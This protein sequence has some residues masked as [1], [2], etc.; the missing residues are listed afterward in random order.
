MERDLDPLVAGG[1]HGYGECSRLGR[2]AGHGHSHDAVPEGHPGESGSGG[3]HSPGEVDVEQGPAGLSM[4]RLIQLKAL[5]GVA[6]GPGIGQGSIHAVE[7]VGDPGDAEGAFQVQ[8]AVD[9]PDYGRVRIG[10]VILDDHGL[11]DQDAV[12]GFAVAGD[13]EALP[14]AEAASHLGKADVPVVDVE[15]QDIF[16]LNRNEVAGFGQGGIGRV[17]AESQ[18]TAVLPEEDPAIE[19]PIEADLNGGVAEPHFPLGHG[20][21]VDSPGK[22]RLPLSAAAPQTE[23]PKEEPAQ[24]CSAVGSGSD[25]GSPAP[26]WSRRLGGPPTVSMSGTGRHHDFSLPEIGKEGACR[27]AVS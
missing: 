24:H 25:S 26:S 3:G 27:P 4:D 7:L 23:D 14:G 9:R 21:K 13:L 10:L 17:V 20:S 18:E 6:R 2:P 16:S 5:E 15:I 1:P 11:L 22:L 19:L 8:V 12:F